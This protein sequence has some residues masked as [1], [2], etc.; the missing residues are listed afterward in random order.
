MSIEATSP[1]LAITLNDDWATKHANSERHYDGL[2]TFTGAELLQAIATAR[3]EEQD[4]LLY[5]LITLAHDGNQAA[6]RVLLQELIAPA[7]EMVHRVTAMDTYSRTDRV[8]VA[9]GAAWESIRSYRLHRTA[10]VRGNLTMETLR[11][12]APRRPAAEAAAHTITVS[13]EDLAEILG[14]WDPEPTPEMELANLFQWARDTGILNREEIALLARVELGTESKREIAA[15][16]GIAYD[17]LRKRAL[18]IRTKLAQGVRTN[19]LE[20]A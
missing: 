14:T 15:D 1:S 7:R 5:T 3:G 10:H 16:L 4:R 13:N 18:R 19:L 20:C 2:G 11:L 8:N 12:L 6:E 17:A 9:I